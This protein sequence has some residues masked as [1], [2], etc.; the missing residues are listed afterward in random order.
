MNT[1][2]VDFVRRYAQQRTTRMHMP[3]HKGRGPLGCEELD[4]TEIAGA[5]ELYEAEGIIAQSEANATQLFGTARTYYSTEGSSQC[6]RAM[7]CLALQAAP[8]T[9]KRPVL[10]AARN[11][12]KALLYAAALL[13]FDIRWL[14]PAAENAGALCSCPISAQMLT[15][16]LQELTGQGSTP[17][18]VYVTSPDY[19]G[20]MQDIR[21]LSAVCDTFGMPLLVDNAHGAY[22]K[23]LSPSRHPM[24]LGADLCCDSAHKTL[25]VVT[26]GAY[27]HI[28]HQAPELLH[29][30]AKASMGL[31]G[32]SSPS[33]LIL[34]SLD[35]ANELLADYPEKL[36]ALLPQLE[37][38]R[39]R[40]AVRGWEL[41]S[42]EPLKVTLCPKG[43]GYTGPEVAAALESGGIYPEF[44]D[45]DHVVLMVSPQNDP[46]DLR[47]LEEVLAA[48]P[49]RQ[50][51]RQG[52]PP[53]PRLEQAVTPHEAM[54]SPWEEVP[55]EA[56]CGRIS[57]A[58]ALGCPPAVPVVLCGQRMDAAA[59]EVLRYYGFHRC[60]VLTE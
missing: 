39:R 5:D 22:L 40:L 12:H 24:D 2:V 55:L 37:S 59:V 42:G 46:S 53:M 17:F 29:R 7:L 34:Q 52:P 15:T 23:F 38:L 14:W 16:A 4:I 36:Q 10:L 32:S 26:G 44:Y 11:A 9:G 6:I 1:P 27:L 33:Y 28:A 58:G 13:D 60:A 31:W 41:L 3:G 19:L 35:A 51:I 8:R 54:L 47:R 43:Y 49:R 30:Q 21:A 50:A 25:P 20:G 48:L 57:A 56:C 18:G 45:P